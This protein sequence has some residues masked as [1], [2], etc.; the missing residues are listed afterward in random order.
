M[1]HITAFFSTFYP[2]YQ[3]FCAPWKRKRDDEAEKQEIQARARAAAKAEEDSREAALAGEAALAAR[4]EEDFY[5]GLG[6]ELGDDGTLRDRQ[7]EDF[8]VEAGVYR[9]G[10][11]KHDKSQDM[12][13]GGNGPHAEDDKGVSLSVIAAKAYGHDG[14]LEG[15]AVPSKLSTDSRGRSGGGGRGGDTEEEEEEALAA[16]AAAAAAAAGLPGLLKEEEMERAYG[17]FCGGEELDFQRFLTG[18]GV[19]R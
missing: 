2:L 12:S 18:L 10:E 19:L 6:A 1:Y 8:D 15:G 13:G 7:R 11:G 3:E 9:H 16:A 14:E 4:S 5:V 17:I